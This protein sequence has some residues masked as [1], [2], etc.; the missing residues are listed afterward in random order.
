MRGKERGKGGRIAFDRMNGG[1]RERQGRGRK[2]GDEKDI[3]RERE[4]KG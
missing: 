3:G 2:D 4:I 1:G